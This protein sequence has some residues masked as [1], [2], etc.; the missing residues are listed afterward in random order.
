M[1]ILWFLKWFFPQLQHIQM[2]NCT[3]ASCVAVKDFCYK[4]EVFKGPINGFLDAMVIGC[5]SQSNLK[6]K[7]PHHLGS[8]FL[9]Q[10]PSW[11]LVWEFD[12]NRPSQNPN[13][14][15]LIKIYKTKW[16]YNFNFFKKT[17]EESIIN[18]LNHRTTP[19]TTASQK[20]LTSLS[21][22]IFIT[23]IT[24][25]YD[26]VVEKIILEIEESTNCSSFT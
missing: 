26:V 7:L 18:L 9:H 21:N 13:I 14:S 4:M 2:M 16:W 12:Y 23:K 17:S 6:L 5:I 25:E 3:T 19:V 24:Y 15:I 8:W 11:I 20:T 22:F 1:W 10:L